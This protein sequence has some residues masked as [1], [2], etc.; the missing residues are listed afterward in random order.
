MV[1][2][3]SFSVH[4]E[5]DI[6]FNDIYF[7]DS[8]SNEDLSTT[9][10]SLNSKINLLKTENPQHLLE[11]PQVHSLQYN[12]N[13]NVFYPFIHSGSVEIVVPL[14]RSICSKEHQRK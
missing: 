14:L 2:Q 7:T 13:S 8:S 6:S 10:A 11:K 1:E 9:F 12:T 4:D 3:I 5:S